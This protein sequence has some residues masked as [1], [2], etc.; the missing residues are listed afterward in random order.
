MRPHGALLASGR[1]SDIFEYGPSLVLRRSRRG[2]SMAQE[3]RAM[4]AARNAGYPV[5]AVDEVS[6][7]GSDLVMERID[8]PSMMDMLGAQPWRLARYATTLADLHRSLHE[9]EAPGFLPPAPGSAGSALVH[10]DLHPMN[11]IIGDK[12][13]VVIDWPNAA[14]GVGAVDVAATWALMACGAI[15]V[16]SLKGAILS[17]FR[18][19][20]VSRFLAP[21][22]ERSV[23]SELRSYVNWK[24]EDENMSEAECA[25]LRRLGVAKAID[26]G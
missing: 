14:H 18:S 10:L 19:L 5:P 7:D 6:D 1:D 21:F 3:A 16:S 15:P 26:T 17:R 4:E 23:R 11:V 9:I 25:A 20:F 22:D 13:P 2:H 12:G 8:G 24:V